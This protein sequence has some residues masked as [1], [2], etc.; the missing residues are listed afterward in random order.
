[1][2]NGVTKELNPN[3]AKQFGAVETLNFERKTVNFKELQ[4]LLRN[5]RELNQK[6]A[7]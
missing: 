4:A 2:G 1:M 5:S 6:V 7:I 3:N